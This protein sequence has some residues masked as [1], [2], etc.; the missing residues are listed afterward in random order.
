MLRFFHA[1]QP[2]KLAQN[3]RFPALE[4]PGSSAAKQNGIIPFSHVFVTSAS[5]LSNLVKFGEGGNKLVVLNQVASEQLLAHGRCPRNLTFRPD[6][7]ATALDDLA[8]P[9]NDEINIAIVNGMGRGYGDNVAGIGALQLLHEVLSERFG[10]INIDLLQRNAK[11]QSVIHQRH[12]VVRL[13]L[14]L[15]ISVRDFFRYDAWFDLSDLLSLSQFNELSLYEFFVHALSLQ[16]ESI[17]RDWH[18]TDL[19]VESEDVR[20]MRSLIK[21]RLPS[22]RTD[23]PLVLVHPVASTPLRTV[24]HDTMDRLFSV[25]GVN[26]EW[27]FLCCAPLER[28]YSGLVDISD[29]SKDINDLVDIVATMDAVVS[30]GTVVYHISGNLGIPTLLL[31]TVAADI[32]SA[33]DLDAVRCHLPRSL[34]AAVSSKHMGR[35]DVELSRVRPLWDA[36]DAHDI[37]AFLQEVV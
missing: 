2:L 19:N 4:F 29:L 32:S 25:L 5:Q 16:S 20:E 18:G 15:P 17:R 31:P 36:L 22:N 1:P 24:P 7:I 3:V 14:Q 13:C 26:D 27:N 6:G 8:L 35:D 30:V 21:H 12:D 23:K 11:I 10:R 33:Q 28:S 9:D 34:K 37:R